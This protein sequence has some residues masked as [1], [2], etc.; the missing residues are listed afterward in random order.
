MATNLNDLESQWRAENDRF[1]NQTQA[2]Q[3]RSLDSNIAAMRAGTGDP[4]MNGFAARD[5]NINSMRDSFDAGQALEQ[6][7]NWAGGRE[8]QH[9]RNLMNSEQE[10][11]NTETQYQGQA[12]L[13]HVEAEKG[14][15]SALSGM[16]SGINSGG[17]GMG[18]YQ[19]P[20]A[21]VEATGA[22]GQHLGGGS[23]LSGMNQPA[24]QQSPLTRRF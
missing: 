16:M 1:Q 10:R 3:K 19:S 23:V 2:M 8:I 13:G 22:N 4:M 21:T 14:L 12:A 5:A 15:N 11:R 9:E 24:R 20:N 6:Q 7:N 17:G 18:G